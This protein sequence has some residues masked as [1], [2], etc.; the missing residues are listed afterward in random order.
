MTFWKNLVVA[1]VAAFAL[2]ACSSS[3]D[4]GDSTSGGTPPPE[5]TPAERQMTLIENAQAGLDTALDGLDA[6][7]PTADQ[8]EAVTDAMS[9]LDDALAGANDLSPN[10]TEEARDDLTDARM[11]AMDAQATLD[12]GMATEERVMMQMEAIADA[13]EA[14]SDAI[15]GEEISD[16]DAANAAYDNLE[17]AIDAGDDLTDAEMASAVSDLNM[18]NVAIANA[19]LAMY[20]T[21]AMADGATLQQMLAAYEGK[22]AAAQRLADAT[23]ASVSD[24][25]TANRAIGEATAKITQLKEDIQDV[26]DDAADE[27]RMDNNDRA[28]AVAE[29]INAHTLPGEP[30]SEFIDP[31]GEPAAGNTYFGV[32]RIS[33]DA[34]FTL[35]QTAAEARKKAYETATAPSAGT[36]WSGQKFTHTDNSGKRPVT[37][38]AAVYT[39]IEMATDAAWASATFQ[40]G[41]VAAD[42]GVTFSGTDDAIRF[43]GILP[44]RPADGETAEIDYSPRAA[45]SGLDLPG[46]FY[47]VSGIYRCAVGG[48]C[49]VSRTT[50]DK[51]AIAGFSF[52]PTPSVADLMAKYATLDTNYTYFGYWMESDENRDG[53]LDHDIETFHGGGNADTLT[54]ANTLLGTAKYYGAAAGVYVKKDGAADSLVVTS[55][56]FTADAELEASFAGTGVA[57]DDHFTVTGE[58]SDFMDGSTN[59]GFDV[60]VLEKAFIGTDG[61]I[62]QTGVANNTPPNFIAGETNGGGTSGNWTGKFYGTA[63]MGDNNDADGNIT[64][65]DYPMD[66]SG[67][68]NGHFADGHVAGAFG[69]EYDE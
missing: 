47:G 62:G 68:F 16:L 53:S 33:D 60:L 52:D 22:L 15:D 61:T 4:N 14:L 37:E 13:Q 69:A 38:M 3:N 36:G 35:T 40:S 10:E 29:A 46:T 5:L 28:M 64:S 2:A 45:T 8:I 18:A 66:V 23:A 6:D 30:S 12:T 41:I 56:Q 1:L 7:D 24:R 39:D 51:V 58:I 65:N 44:P 19:E 11:A 43:T 9:L 59:L 25:A 20:E 17:L 50:A 21:A 49:T 42:G 32:E 27:M 31:D 55:G 54:L 34:T 63:N 57:A 26:A 48:T 67:Q